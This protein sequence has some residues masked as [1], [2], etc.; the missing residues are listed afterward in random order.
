MGEDVGMVPK[1]GRGVFGFEQLGRDLRRRMGFRVPGSG[2]RV[3]GS[4]FRVPGFRNQEP[5]TKNQEP[6]TRKAKLENICR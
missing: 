4:G 3:P 6:G 1:V 2:F 5:G